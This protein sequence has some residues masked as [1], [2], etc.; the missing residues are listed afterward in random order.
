MNK[1]NQTAYELASMI[2]DMKPDTPLKAEMIRERSA[3]IIEFAQAY[4]SSTTSEKE[5]TEEQIQIKSEN[6]ATTRTSF[7]DMYSNR[8]IAFEEGMKAM[9]DFTKSR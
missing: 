8:K 1:D 9:R 2:M 5:I 3:S 7:S 4:A 6:Y